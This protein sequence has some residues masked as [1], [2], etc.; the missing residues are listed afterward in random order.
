M[1]PHCGGSGGGAG[2]LARAVRGPGVLFRWAA[3]QHHGTVATRD[4]GVDPAQD[5]HPPVEAHHFAI[6]GAGWIRD[7]GPI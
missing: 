6:V 3:H 4:L 1:L 2:F 7:F 5:Q